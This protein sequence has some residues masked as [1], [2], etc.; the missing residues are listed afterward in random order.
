M[1]TEKTPYDEYIDQT[2]GDI[3]VN[4]VCESLSVAVWGLVMAKAR[5]S[6]ALSDLTESKVM[7]SKLSK[8]FYLG[9]MIAFAQILKLSAENNYINHFI[10]QV[11]IKVDGSI[12]Q[13]QVKTSRG[14]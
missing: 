3:K 12:N 6:F 8:M 1:Y 10:D 14:P 5:S 13:P 9:I 4:Q 7:K 2:N 11:E